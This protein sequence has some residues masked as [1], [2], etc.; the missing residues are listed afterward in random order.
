MLK[1][2]DPKTKESQEFY[3]Y[4]KH[5]SLGSIIGD[6]TGQSAGVERLLNQFFD[7]DLKSNPHPD[8]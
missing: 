7:R 1:V 5:H 4:S 6:P 2:T 3:H 8:D